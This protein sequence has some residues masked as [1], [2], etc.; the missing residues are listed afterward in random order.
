MAS[1]AFQDAF[2]K[3]LPETEN[4]ID[5]FINHVFMKNPDACKMCLGDGRLS[6]GGKLSNPPIQCPQCKGTGQEAK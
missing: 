3:V 2:D 5:S 1:K 4:L 6:R